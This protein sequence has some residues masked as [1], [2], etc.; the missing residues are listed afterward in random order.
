[1]TL[2]NTRMKG[3]VNISRKYHKTHSLP[4]HISP[5]SDWWE[6]APQMYE[7]TV[8]C[9]PCWRTCLAGKADSVVSDWCNF[10]SVLLLAIP[11]ALT[12]MVHHWS[13]S[14]WKNKGCIMLLC[15]FERIL[16]SISSV[17]NTASYKRRS[18]ICITIPLELLG[19]RRIAMFTLDQTTNCS[20][21]GEANRELP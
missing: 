17:G 11:T 16:G 6:Q 20:L 5:P 18:Y 15:E 2:K 21:R 10:P 4:P 8:T 1:M 7:I 3:Q 14:V 12:L 13:S 9:A 19:S